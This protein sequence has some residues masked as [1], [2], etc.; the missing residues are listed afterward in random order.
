MMYFLPSD[1]FQIREKRFI[2][3]AASDERS[4]I[5]RPATESVNECVLL[6]Q[7]RRIKFR[8]VLRVRW[9]NP[10]SKSQNPNK[11]QGLKFQNPGIGSRVG[12]W[13]LEFIWIL[14]FRARNGKLLM[15]QP[16][17]LPVRCH[18]SFPCE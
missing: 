10:K 5:Y 13:S 16:W 12:T 17:L 1:E 8:V 6:P 4:E 14:E 7:G 11:F 9:E 3:F 2:S 18:L 15:R